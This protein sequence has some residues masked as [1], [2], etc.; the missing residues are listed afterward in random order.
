ML[1]ST[2]RASLGD[3]LTPR[4]CRCGGARRSRRCASYRSR[5]TINQSCHERGSIEPEKE[6]PAKVDARSVWNFAKPAEFLSPQFEVGRHFESGIAASNLCGHNN[7]VPINSALTILNRRLGRIYICGAQGA[8]AHFQVLIHSPT[9]PPATEVGSTLFCTFPRTASDEHLARPA[10]KEWRRSGGQ[11][12]AVVRAAGVL[13][14]GVD[15]RPHYWV[16]H[17]FDRKTPKP[18][19]GST[20]SID[21]MKR[22]AG[23]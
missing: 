4:N 14:L 11:S 9:I 10:E 8:G 19:D 6:F 17:A 2:F 15:C 22:E 12:G 20:R 7:P 16:L 3:E 13:G 23:L 21:R 18:A 1:H 5:A